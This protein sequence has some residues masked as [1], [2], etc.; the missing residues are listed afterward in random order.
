MSDPNL[1]QN[2]VSGPVVSPV[3]GRGWRF[4]FFVLLAL[5]IGAAGIVAGAALRD[6]GSR[7]G[8]IR[9]IGFG[10]FN[11]ALSPDDRAALRSSFLK[12]LPEM[13]DMRRMMRA[14][15]DALLT[16]L[17]AEPFDADALKTALAQFS[18]RGQARLELGQQL[19]VERIATMSDQQRTMFADRLE[20]TLRRGPE[21]KTQP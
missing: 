20:D 9:D 5:N 8:A 3:A 10:P 18:A 12:R 11:A 4:A 1:P 2:D 14:D 19:I 7:F 21:R 6:G 13:R 15:M 17:R 16:A